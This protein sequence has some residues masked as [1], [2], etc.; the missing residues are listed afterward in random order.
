MAF[1]RSLR[2]IRVSLPGCFLAALTLAVLATACSAEPQRIAQPFEARPTP[3]PDSAPTP[4]PTPTPTSTPAPEQTATPITDWNLDASSTGSDLLALLSIDERPCIQNSLGDRFS[5]FQT[6]AF[7]EN[8]DAVTG[9]ALEE[10]LTPESKAGFAVSMFSATASGLSAETRNCLADVLTRNP[11]AAI[12]FATDA[13]PSNGAQAEALEA[14]SCLSPEEAAAMTR[15]G[16]GP[17]PDT[18]GLRCLTEELAKVEGGDE[19]LRIFSTADP[20]G[21]TPEQSASLGQAVSNCGIETDFTFPEPGATSSEDGSAST[22]EG[23]D[24]PSP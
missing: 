14:L 5:T 15:E 21:L 22:D 3:T 7:I 19:I 23:T 9:P 4:A 1:R 11:Q 16:E 2:L 24:T 12:G 6:E 17:P 20:A 10:C 18:T 8:L 13:Q